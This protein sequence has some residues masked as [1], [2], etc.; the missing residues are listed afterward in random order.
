NALIDAWR[1]LLRDESLDPAMVAQLL[2]LP[3]EAQLSEL[4]EEI[5]VIAI[6]EAREFLRARLASAL[7]S[8]W[9]ATYQRCDA[10]SGAYSPDAAS[11]G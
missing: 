7:E 2:R 6:H 3:S 8:E 1:E 5:D 11:I 4:A 9:L 10:A